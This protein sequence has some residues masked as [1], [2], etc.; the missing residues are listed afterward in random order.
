MMA[1]FFSAAELTETL[2]APAR[3]M[4]VKSSTV[5]MPPPTVKGMKMLSATRVTMSTMMSRASEEAV[6]S[7]ST[8][9]SAPWLSYSMAHSTG[10]P[11]SR[12]P[13]K[14]VPF[15]TR[16]FF[17]SRQGMIRLAYMLTPP[18]PALPRSSPGFA[19]PPGRFSPGG[20]G[21]PSNCPCAPPR[22]WWPHTPPW[23]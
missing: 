17:R 23:P 4:R 5:R 19:A 16:P 20:T 22:G 18:F 21:R 6:M 12:R 2:S 7:S 8:S 1:G 10:S 11:A 14:L 3:R 9:S 13:T 15:T